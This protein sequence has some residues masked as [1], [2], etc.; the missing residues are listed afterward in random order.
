MSI[1]IFKQNFINKFAGFSCQNKL[2]SLNDKVTQLERKIEFLEAR[3]CFKG[4]FEIIIFLLFSFVEGKH[5]IKMSSQGGRI[6]RAGVEGV[7]KKI[8]P[9]SSH[10]P[11][12]ARLGVLKVYKKL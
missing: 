7:I 4:F 1:V 5:S 3:V 12:E 10:T 6:V 2:S 8:T 9:V 11:E